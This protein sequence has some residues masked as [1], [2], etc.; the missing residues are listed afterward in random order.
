MQPDAD[1]TSLADC[2]LRD[3]R[4]SANY[5]RNLLCIVRYNIVTTLKERDKNM[6][7]KNLEELNAANFALSQALFTMSDVWYSMGR[8]TDKGW[9]DFFRDYFTYFTETIPH[10][11]MYRDA[12]AILS[13]AVLLDIEP[14][15]FKQTSEK[16][17]SAGKSDKLLDFLIYSKYPEHPVSEELMISVSDRQVIDDIID[18]QDE[19]AV[20]SLKC[21]LENHYYTPENLGDAYDAHL[22]DDNAYQGYWAWEIAA[23]VKIKQLNDKELRDNPYYPAAMMPNTDGYIPTELNSC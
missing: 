1:Q 23:V 22:R 8:S 2:C 13:L 9:Q 12:L 17:R 15:Y 21:Y 3:T 7:R 6:R 10:T 11:F 14:H 5:F 16:I 18:S 19:N 20:D 4:R